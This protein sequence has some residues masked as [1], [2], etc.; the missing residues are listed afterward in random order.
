LSTT[1]NEKSNRKR[2][3]DNGD[4]DDGDSE[5]AA[6]AAKDAA[7]ANAASLASQPKFVNLSN[8]KEGSTSSKRA[9]RE[10]GEEYRSKK[11]GGDVWRKGMLEPH[12]FIPLGEKKYCY[13]F[14]VATLFPSLTFN[15]LRPPFV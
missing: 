9:R 11:S 15:C 4:E 10:P 1:G 14:Y 5:A 8:S 13:Y 7:D 12:A 6:A 3:R 2:C